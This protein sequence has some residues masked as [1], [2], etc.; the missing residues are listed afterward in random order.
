MFVIIFKTRS[1]TNI[2]KV[3]W[4]YTEVDIL[5]DTENVGKNYL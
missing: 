5:F 4:L 1:L 3:I 2:Q